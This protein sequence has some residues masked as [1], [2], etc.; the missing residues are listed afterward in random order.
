MARSKCK[1]TGCRKWQRGRS[2]YCGRHTEPNAAPAPEKRVPS[3]PTLTTKRIYHG[4]LATVPMAKLF[5]RNEKHGTLVTTC[6]QTVDEHTGTIS[7]GVRQIIP[8]PQKHWKTILPIMETVTK[9]AIQRVPNL[10]CADPTIRRP[11]IVVA[12]PVTSRSNPWTK[13]GIHRDVELE[14]ITGYYTFHYLLTPVTEDNG[15]IRVWP[16]TATVAFDPRVGVPKPHQDHSEDKIGAPGD[17]IVHDSRI[18][19]QSL[20]N[21][22]GE[23]RLTLTW[24]VCSRRNKSKVI[25]PGYD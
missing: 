12:P 18:L 6:E 24:H 20:P 4:V 11:E 13:G 5:D 16:N 21:T 9:L 7:S 19:H 17:L 15:A 25:F 10:R 22:T 14:T 23:Q 8:L 2:R 3:V 1:T